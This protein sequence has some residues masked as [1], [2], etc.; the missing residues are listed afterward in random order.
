MHAI[1]QRLHNS[2]KQTH[3]ILLLL[4]RLLSAASYSS[5][6]QC[7]RNQEQNF[8]SQSNAMG[9]ILMIFKGILDLL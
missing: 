6:K 4:K 7:C 9:Y 5:I 2:G 1:E 8:Y 3:V